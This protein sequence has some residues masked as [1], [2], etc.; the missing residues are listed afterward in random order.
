MDRI[1]QHYEIRAQRAAQ[2]KKY[3]VWKNNRT[4]IAMLL[5]SFGCFPSILILGILRIAK[6]DERAGV[7]FGYSI[8]FFT[9][10]LTFYLAALIFQPALLGSLLSGGKSNNKQKIARMIRLGYVSQYVTFTFSVVAA[11]APLIIIAD[12]DKGVTE[13][14]QIVYIVSRFAVEC[15]SFIGY[16]CISVLLV[17]LVL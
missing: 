16:T 3:R 13:I 2:G 8:L 17:G 15:D 10:K 12:P 1:R 11:V 9:G 6:E 4:L 7:T 5:Y 14:A